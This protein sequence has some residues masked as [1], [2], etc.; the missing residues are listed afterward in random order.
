MTIYWEKF[1]CKNLFEFFQ[2]CFFQQKILMGKKFKTKQKKP[3]N[4][5]QRKGHREG[6]HHI[7]L[8]H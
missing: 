5:E 2:V 8:H 1:F 3:I 6:Y 4:F 7:T